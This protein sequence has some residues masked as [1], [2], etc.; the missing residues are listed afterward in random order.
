M[1]SSTCSACGSQILDDNE[2][3]S[4]SGPC[5]LIFH[6]H[7]VGISNRTY[8][9][10][11]TDQMLSTWKCISCKQNQPATGKSEDKQNLALSDSDDN[12]EHQ[13]SLEVLGSDQDLASLVKNE[14]KSLKKYIQEHFEEYEKSLEHNSLLIQDLNSTISGL[15][16]ELQVLK[17]E[18]EELKKENRSIAIELKQVKNEVADLQQYSRRKNMEIS[19]LPEEANEN[20]N[21]VLANVFS[22]LEVDLMNQVATVHRVPT[23][24]KDKPKPI[25]VQF[26]RKQ[27]RDNCLK[28]AKTKRLSA[29]QI[30]TRFQDKPIFLNEHLTPNR[31]ELFFHCRKFKSNNNYKYAWVK[32]GKIFIRKDEDSRVVR[33]T[34]TDDLLNVI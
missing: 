34:C 12:K 25:I 32:D 13:T 31:K 21:E 27:D 26:I 7:C 11:K 9:K 15:T 19:N 30:N 10:L 20:I 24:N 5:G 22:G 8:R 14:I 33:I 28:A 17:K 4:C 3:M 6:G 18:K 1:S 16:S 29:S 23:S 2:V